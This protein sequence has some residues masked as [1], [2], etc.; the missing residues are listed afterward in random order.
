MKAYEEDFLQRTA[1]LS[2]AQRRGG[3]HVSSTATTGSAVTMLQDVATSAAAAA[4]SS[5]LSPYKHIAA[6]EMSMALDTL[7]RQSGS[8]K[9]AA[10]AAATAT[11][12][13]S[14]SASSSLSVNAL[15]PPRKGTVI[16][17]ATGQRRLTVVN[18]AADSGV[19]FDGVRDVLKKGWTEG[20]SYFFSSP[21]N[22][23]KAKKEKE[24]A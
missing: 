19:A 8:K 17:R 16:D 7:N 4:S 9:A 6:I 23:G 13:A 11:A 5:E 14:A 15:P 3:G 21:D 1:R 24:T 22:K 20:Q 10:V 18:D 2:R 12:S